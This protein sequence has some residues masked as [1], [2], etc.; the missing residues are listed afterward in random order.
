MTTPFAEIHRTA[1]ARHGD[2]ETESRLP[3]PQDANALRAVSDDRYFSLMTL[4]IF[5]AGLKHSLVRSKWPAF[6]DAFLG[7]EPPRV[8]FMNDDDLDRLM[9][10]QR[11]IRHGGK[12]RATLHNAS[13]MMQV[14]EEK[15]SFGAY[16][17]DWAVEDIAG[18]WDDLG[19]RF[20]QLGGNS[21]PYFLRM[22]GK[23]TWTLSKDVVKGLSTW[24]GLPDPRKS[25]KARCAAQEIFNH[26]TRE[27]TR[28]LCQLSMILALSVD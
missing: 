4:R 11:L 17:A 26:W 2:A 5:S 12:M 25:K 15:G 18:L 24:E 3:K 27:T 8:A 10:D 9:G 20:K 28:P 23:D 21:A 7:F 19:K 13:A 6:E 22:A 16:L 1:V 14:V